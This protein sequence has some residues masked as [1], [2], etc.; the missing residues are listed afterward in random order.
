LED[1]YLVVG[2][3]AVA[4]VLFPLLAMGAGALFR[5]HNPD[6]RKLSTYECGEIPFGDAHIQFLPQYY[7]VALMFLLFDVETVF[8]YPWA[9]VYRELGL[10]GLLE[11]AVFILLLVVALLY[12]W[13]EKV[14]R[15]V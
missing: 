6:S 8:L 3:F 7:I 10:F 5:P 1:N 11:M 15:W 2:V 13:R 4:G 12:A 9:V 14:L